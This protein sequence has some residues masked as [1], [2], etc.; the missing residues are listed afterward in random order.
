MCILRLYY[1]IFQRKWQ[2]ESLFFCKKLI[3]LFYKKL[4]TSGIAVRLPVRMRKSGR[5]ERFKA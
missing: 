4:V 1:S 5:C 2:D 3:A